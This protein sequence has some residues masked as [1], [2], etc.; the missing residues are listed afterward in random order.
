[1]AASSHTFSELLDSIRN[2][3]GLALV[4]AP[5]AGITDR[6]F[7]TVCVRH[8][9]RFT[10]SEMV[11]AKGLFYGGEKTWQLVEPAP[12]EETF[13]VQLFGSEPDIMAGQAAAVQERLGERLAVI[14]VN[15]GCPVPKV[16][17]KGEGAALM[18]TPEQACAVIEAMVREVTVPVTAKIR[19]GWSADEVTAPS[20]AEALEAAGVCGIAVH[21]RAA[22]QLYTG[23]ADRDVIAQVKERVDVPVLGSG[24]VY[25]YEDARSMMQQAGCDAVMVA[26]GARGNPWIFED[27]TPTDAE[28]VEAAEEHLDL[29][30]AFCSD[31]HLSPLRAQLAWYMHGMQRASGI[32][33]ELGDSSTAEDFRAVLQ[34][35]REQAEAVSC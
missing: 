15:M 4:L 6:A 32:R 26:R 24:D 30:L 17:K 19:S 13:A 5:M 16:T 33:R 18:Q 7:R 20:F 12:E 8:G 21:G 25:S 27:R 22:T 14:D 23:S 31:E 10:Y 11:S 3:D 1:M 29:Y 9:A 28:R 34:R 2:P 35:V